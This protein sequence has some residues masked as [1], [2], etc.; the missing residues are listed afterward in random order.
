[1][2]IITFDVNKTNIYG[3]L[4]EKVLKYFSKKDHKIFIEN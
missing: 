2:K 3:D 1:M 4:K